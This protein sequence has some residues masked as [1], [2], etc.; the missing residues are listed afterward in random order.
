[1]KKLFE[2]L[3]P[4]MAKHMTKRRKI[5][6]GA[7]GVVSLAT[8]GFF[9]VTKPAAQGEPVVATDTA[10]APVDSTVIDSTATADSASLA[11]AT[12]ASDSASTK[13]AVKY[14]SGEDPAFAEK[15]GW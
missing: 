8:F 10:L 1:M 5:A 14:R 15:M 11:P 2:A 3:L 12:A 9:A 6:L 4:L 13:P 7:L